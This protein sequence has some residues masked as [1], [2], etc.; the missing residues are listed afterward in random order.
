MLTKTINNKNYID[1]INRYIIRYLFFDN[2]DNNNNKTIMRILI[3]LFKSIYN[4]RPN[5][6]KKYA[7][8]RIKPISALKWYFNKFI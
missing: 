3:T 7:H 2:N 8:K 6:K 4:N 1:K 5:K